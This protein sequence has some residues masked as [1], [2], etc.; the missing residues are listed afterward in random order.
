MDYKNTIRVLNEYLDVFINNYKGKLASEGWQSGKLYNSVRKVSVR[1]SG[2]DFSLTLSLEDYWKYIEEGRKAGKQPNRKK[3]PPI[4][5]I[6]KW[7]DRKNIIPRPIKLKSGKEFSPTRN[8]LAFLISRSI[9]K[10]GFKTAIPPK[11]FFKTSLQTANEMFIEKIKEALIQ[12]LIENGF[13][14]EKEGN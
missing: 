14:N 8:T 4:T 9:L 11:P 13:N 12:D 2:G 3:M 5:E 7:I 10:N 6:R 1:N